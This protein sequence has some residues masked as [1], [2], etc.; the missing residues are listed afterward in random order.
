MIPSTNHT[1][2][3]MICKTFAYYKKNHHHRAKRANSMSATHN[4]NKF[5]QHPN[6]TTL[7]FQFSYEAGPTPACSPLTVAWS[8]LPGTG[9]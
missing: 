6:I 3:R 9:F 5:R 1:H 2:L 4:K 8:T 7:T